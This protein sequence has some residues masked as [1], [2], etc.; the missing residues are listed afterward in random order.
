MRTRRGFQNR[1][2]LRLNW[3]SRDFDVFIGNVNVNFRANAKFSFEIN[4]GLDGKTNSRNDSPRITRLEVVDVNAIAVGFLA[5]R[6]TG[7]MRELFA[8]TCACNYATRDVVHFGA[9][10][11][12]TSTD[13]LA[14]ELDRR[15]ACF[16]HDVENP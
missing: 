5:N 1:D 10:N 16:A 9:S 14:H 15:I 6:V 3:L 8:K 11:R 12:F 4:P 7:A 13:I 2:Y